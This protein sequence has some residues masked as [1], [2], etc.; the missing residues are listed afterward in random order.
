MAVNKFSTKILQ[1]DVMF[2]EGGSDVL[3]Q[4]QS[5]L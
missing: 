2:Y 4:I 1:K 5:D 3:E